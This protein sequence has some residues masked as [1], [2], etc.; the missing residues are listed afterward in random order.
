[1]ATIDIRG[2]NG[3]NGHD[4]RNGVNYGESGQNAGPAEAA[5]NG[6]VA[7]LRLSRVPDRPSAMQIV[8]TVNNLPYNQVLDFGPTSL[9]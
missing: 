8:G 6:G 2:F 3:K 5:G 1:M 9:L 4:G 7:Y